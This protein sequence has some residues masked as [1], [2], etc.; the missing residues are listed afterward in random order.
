MVTDIADLVGCS[1]PQDGSHIR[2]S[3]SDR[4]WNG[5]TVFGMLLGYPAVYYFEG[6][7][8]SVG[9]GELVVNSFE[10]PG[11]VSFSYPAAITSLADVVKKWAL[12]TR[13][14]KKLVVEVKSSQGCVL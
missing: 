4:R 3:A 10:G 11:D 6:D 13:P 2:L 7:D 14:G 8:Y 9:C 5:A 12:R 1:S